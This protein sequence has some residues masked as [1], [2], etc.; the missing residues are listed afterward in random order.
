VPTSNQIDLKKILEDFFAYLKVE[1]GLSQNT[2]ASY[3]RD[4]RHYFIFISAKQLDFLQISEKNIEEYIQ[5]LQL[6]R[7][8]FSPTS[9]ARMISALKT[10]YRY[11]LLQ[12]YLNDI[13]FLKVALP[14][15][16]LRLPKALTIEEVEDFLDFSKV[17]QTPITLRDQGVL[18]FLYATG[19]RASEV[20]DLKI[21]D[22]DFEE[23]IVRLTGKGDKTRI[24]PINEKCCLLL[25]NYL[26]ISRPA[27]ASKSTGSTWF[28]LNKRGNKL[29]RQSIWEI[30]ETQKNRN[31]LN[32]S[33][34]P[35]SL[36]HSFATHLLQG[37]ADL[38]IVQ[39]LLGHASLSTTEIYTK[40]ETQT[41]KEIYMLNHPHAKSKPF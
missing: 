20:S 24:V 38:R 13:S 3:D 31:Q 33:F 21:G 4:L 29:T 32:L 39:E 19:A 2:I 11:L 41:L 22:L 17:V 7:P 14:K 40:V 18:E 8:K 1:K 12:D 5:E 23:H 28:F 35:H 34:S 37:G 25:K 30:I 9:I 15:R 36:R 10:F 27:L 6:V 16:G 26:S